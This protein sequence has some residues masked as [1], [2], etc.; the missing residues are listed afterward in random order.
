MGKLSKEQAKSAAIGISFI[1]ILI[2]YVQNDQTLLIY[3]VAWM[4][5]YLFFPAILVIVFAPLHYLFFSIIGPLF[6]KSML[7]VTFILFIT[8]LG[9]IR[10][11]MG[12]DPL[13]LKKWKQNNASF[14]IDRE[15]VFKSDDLNKPY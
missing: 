13:Q 5:C 9:Y 4:L 6:S 1:I 11:I 8:P 15:I 7:I 10:R 3:A 14:F 2:S 12:V